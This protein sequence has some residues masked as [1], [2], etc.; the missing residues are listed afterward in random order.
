MKKL[1]TIVIFLWA[2][3][4]VQ[5]QTQ[6]FVD[7]FLKNKDSITIYHNG[8]GKEMIP[9]VHL[10]LFAEDLIPDT[11]GKIDAGRLLSQW[12]QYVLGR[13]TSLRHFYRPRDER[14]SSL[15]FDFLEPDFILK[16]YLV[17]YAKKSETQESL[18]HRFMWYRWGSNH[19]LRSSMPSD[20]LT[21]R[22]VVCFGYMPWPEASED[23]WFL[24][25]DTLYT[26]YILD[27]LKQIRLRTV[28][29]S[30]DSIHPSFA[31]YFNDFDSTC[32]IPIDLRKKIA[33][34][35]DDEISGHSSISTLPR[36]LRK[37]YSSTK[38]D[39]LR[40]LGYIPLSCEEAY[41]LRGKEEH[42]YGNIFLISIPQKQ[43]IEYFKNE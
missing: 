6:T 1:I 25:G 2:V 21:E 23:Y 10:F 5:A 22:T 32:C 4:T 38:E 29:E 40:N 16:P 35:I 11:S 20:K 31:R 8:E 34:I 33:S 41:R 26:G 28:Q 27:S 39:C 3:C 12:N 7:S 36:R 13:T 15:A 30:L 42:Y 14:N 37:H 18:L 19:H 43:D 24:K 17:V 9:I